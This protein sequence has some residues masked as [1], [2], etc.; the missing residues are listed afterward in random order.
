MSDVNRH[1]IT[2]IW[3]YTIIAMYLFKLSL[4]CI[5]IIL[6]IWNNN[7]FSAMIHDDVNMSCQG[8]ELC[9][10]DKFIAT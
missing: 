2:L 6:I 5:Y 4:V 7:T 10:P 9:G 1:Q 8:S 3:D